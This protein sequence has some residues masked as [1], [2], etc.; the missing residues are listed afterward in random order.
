MEKISHIHQIFIQEN[1]KMPRSFPDS[2]IENTNFIRNLYPKAKY[3][4]YSGDEIRDFISENFDEIVLHAYDT[5]KPYAY[6]CDLGRLCLLYIYGGLYVD[7]G[8]RVFFP[9]QIDNKKN[10]LLFRCP[11]HKENHPWDVE[12]SIMYSTPKREEFKIAID[13]ICDNVKKRFY[14]VNTL[15]PTGPGVIGRAI[16]IAGAEKDYAIGFSSVSNTPLPVHFFN[17]ILPNGTFVATRTKNGRLSVVIEGANDYN[18]FWHAGIVY[19]EPTVF[20]AEHFHPKSSKE[21][22][23][24]KA[25]AKA[26]LPFSSKGIIIWGPYGFLIAGRYNVTVLFSENSITDGLKIDLFDKGLGVLRELELSDSYR[27]SANEFKF[28]FLNP[29]TSRLLE[30][31]FHSEG[32]AKGALIS[33]TFDLI[34]DRVVPTVF[35]AENFYS[36]ATDGKPAG[37]TVARYGIPYAG[38]GCI[39]WGPYQFLR[40]GRYKVNVL[41]GENSVTEGLK[42]NL[43]DQ[44]LGVL[45]KTNLSHAQRVSEREFTFEFHNSYTSRLFEVRLFGDGRAKG[46]LVSVTFFPI[47][48]E[49]PD[50]SPTVAFG[51][52]WRGMKRLLGGS[53]RAS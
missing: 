46:T 35:S 2:I 8:V 50:A 3:K 38:R 52:K 44:G 12:N 42:L 32:K 31:R 22:E 1:G 7:L 33:V 9:L 23:A 37:K 51:K 25:I 15:A 18:D 5:L 19:G 45:H 17:Y 6:K 24:G 39:I 10:I 36:N 21:K 16:A 40:E 11:L 4:I 26:G 48:E 53:P 29:H 13:I 30:A 43:F 47:A 27:V 41:F 49:N 20:L 34:D 28:E 14:G